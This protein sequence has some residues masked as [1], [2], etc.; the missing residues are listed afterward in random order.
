MIEGSRSDGGMFTPGEDLSARKLNHLADL[1]SRHKTTTNL[2][3][4]TKQ[5]P[6]GT[7]YDVDSEM[8]QDQTFDYPFKV[9]V[10]SYVEK[11]G[12]TTTTKFR[13]FIRAG[14][15]NS[16][17]PKILGGVNDGKYIDEWNSTTNTF[18]F[19]PLD[20]ATYDKKYVIMRAKV[21]EQKKFF[22]NETQ[23][24]LVDNLEAITD[25]DEYGHLVI[26]GIVLIKESGKIKSIRAI[27]QYIYSSQSLIR[28]KGGSAI[29]S[30]T[31]R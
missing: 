16:F 26:A 3:L 12:S 14:T 31:S 2:G 7:V 23:V 29:W 10:S 28:I 24:Y 5:G 4:K 27:N 11:S 21:N 17:I 15:V 19:L 18:V 1:A 22:P 30:W 20:S 8:P 6:F 25:T 9:T 13:V